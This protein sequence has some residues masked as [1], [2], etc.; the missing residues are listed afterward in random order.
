M[1][2][3]AALTSSVSIAEVSIATVQDRLKWSRRTATLAMLLPLTV[4]STLCAL[5]FSDLSSV[6]IFGLTIFDFLDR[7]TTDILLPLVSL[8][9]C[10]YVGWFAPRN[11]LRD[12]LTNEGT[13]HSPMSRVFLLII[14]YIAPLLIA[15]IFINNYL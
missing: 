7:F 11:L 4:I 6:K 3:V 9:V 5:S 1:L 13:L 12:Q 15:M 2:F 8:G 10:I 14:R